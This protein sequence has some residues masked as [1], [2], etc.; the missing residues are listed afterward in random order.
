[1]HKLDISIRRKVCENEH[2]CLCKF[3]QRICD[4]QMGLAELK[5]GRMR[6]SEKP[7]PESSIPRAQISPQ[8]F[9][10]GFPS[11]HTP[12]YHLK[13][14]KKSPA[15]SGQWPICNLEKETGIQ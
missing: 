11:F 6:N 7:L 15:E 10:H 2:K 3:M 4:T 1:M 14:Y 8:Q 13:V 12:S 5:T 9:K